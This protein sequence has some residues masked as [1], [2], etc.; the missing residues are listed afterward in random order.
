MKVRR[1]KSG[2]AAITLLSVALIPAMVGTANAQDNTGADTN[3][4]G[5][6]DDF[7]GDGFADDLDGDCIPDDFNGDGVPDGDATDRVCPTGQGGSLPT[8]LSLQQIVFVLDAIFQQLPDVTMPNE[9]PDGF[10]NIPRIVDASGNDLGPDW[11]ALDR[12]LGEPGQRDLLQLPDNNINEALL[13]FEDINNE[14]FV[15]PTTGETIFVATPEALF[16]TMGQISAAGGNMGLVAGSGSALKGPCMGQAWSF[17]SD[18]QPLDMA[19]DFDRELA[20]MSFSDDPNSNELVQAF[21]S[22]NPF[23]VDVDGAVIY[24][25]IA[26][27][28]GNG[29]GPVEHDWFINMNFVGFAGT[30]IDAGGDPNTNGENRNAGAVSLHEDLPSA[31]KINGLIAVNGQMEAPGTLDVPGHQFFCVASGFVEFEGGLPLTAPGVALLTL[32]T[33][34][35]LFNARPAK[36]W[37]GA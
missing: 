17:D 8:R 3:G 12:F 9:A 1:L 23:R 14:Q 6:A 20:P 27:G 36:T 10:P 5:V 22:D 28:F 26:G 29:T 33:V 24:T 30:N 7:N 13:E 34:G 2:L 11:A 31:A 32:A 25:G 37:G 18:G 21:A 35:L 19:F 4:D 15:D 16:Y